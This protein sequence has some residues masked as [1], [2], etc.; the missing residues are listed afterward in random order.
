M[1]SRGLQPLQLKRNRSELK[2]HS[3]FNSLHHAYGVKRLKCPKLFLKKE[4]LR[5]AERTRGGVRGRG[6]APKGH[7]Y[8]EVR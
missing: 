8:E 4:I 1:H 3:S 2:R 6:K 5:C 7:A